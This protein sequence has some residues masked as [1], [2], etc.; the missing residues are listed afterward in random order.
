MCLYIYDVYQSEGRG[1]EYDSMRAEALMAVANLL[2][3]VHSLKGDHKVYTQMYA[4]YI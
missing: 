1:K 3:E 2:L 4:S